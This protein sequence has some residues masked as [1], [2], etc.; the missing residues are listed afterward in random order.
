MIRRRDRSTSD[1]LSYRPPCDD[2]HLRWTQFRPESATGGGGV[3]AS[4]PMSW[5]ARAGGHKVAI[6]IA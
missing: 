3:D 1:T 5:I 4:G 6:R 2:G